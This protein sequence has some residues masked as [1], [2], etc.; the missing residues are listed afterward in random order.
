MPT[1]DGALY[2]RAALE[3][4]RIQADEKVEI[5]AVDD[6]SD[7][8]TL[9][10]LRSY[11]A[12]LPLK[13]IARERS[14]NWVANTN[15]GLAA[16]SGEWVCFLHQDDAWLPGRLAMI[17]ERLAQEPEASL[18]LHAARFIDTQG[19]GIGLWRCPLPSHPRILD[20]RLLLERL[21][22]QNFIAIPAPVFK[23]DLLLQV[24]GLDEKLWYTADWDF[25]LKLS[26]AAW[27]IYLP[28]ALAE[29]RIHPTSQTMRRSGGV[30]DLRGQL[31][32]VLAV[33]FPAREIRG[34][35]GA[36]LHRVARFSVDMNVNLAAA[37]HGEGADW[38]RLG[39]QFLLLG[40]RGWHR[41]CR[42]SR[43]AERVFSRIRAGIRPPGPLNLLASARRLP[44]FEGACLTATISPPHPPDSARSRGTAS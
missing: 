3:S 12:K 17:R 41:Y 27:T 19:K 28:K 37:A 25:W 29:F 18:V 1:C 14:G 9:A 33:H 4:V 43:I 34:G 44:P 21:L 30:E 7:D 38:L 11:A 6:G 26:Q 32:S 23:R 22:V 15:C 8:A 13:I 40:A 39:C 36:A 16:A 24:G 2:L 10:I 20:R 31:E 42:D 35:D 5:I